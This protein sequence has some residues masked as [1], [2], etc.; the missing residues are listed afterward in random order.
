MAYF[1]HEDKV[2]KVTSNLDIKE[3]EAAGSKQCDKDGKA[4]KPGEASKD[5]DL[6]GKK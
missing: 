2:V 1:K 4:L 3:W 6:F 5:D